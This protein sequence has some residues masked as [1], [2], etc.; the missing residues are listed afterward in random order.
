MLIRSKNQMIRFL[1]RPEDEGVIPPPE[2]AKAFLPDWFRKLPAID[3][4]AV[5]TSDTGLTVKHC[6]PFLDAM[7]TGWII[8]LAATVRLEIGDDG[9]TVN[10][11]SGDC[12][13]ATVILTNHPVALKTS[14]PRPRRNG[15]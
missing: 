2:S 3:K 15:R 13:I 8:P 12:G 9:K 4:Q 1:C 7:T 11:G 10:T 5:T 6:M 14:R